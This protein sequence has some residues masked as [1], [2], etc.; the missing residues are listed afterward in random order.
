MSNLLRAVHPIA[1]DFL[2]TMVFAA[3]FGLTH[4]L[5]LAL[6]AALSVGV[7]QIAWRR[8]RGEPIEL[9][10][11]AGLGLAL[12]FGG[13]SLLAHDVRFV[14]FKPTL[15]YVAV[16]AV[17]LKPGWMDRY[18]PPIVH[19][20]LG[21]AALTRWG[22]A[23]AA[24]M[25]ATAAA[26]LALALHSD[27]KLWGAFITIGP[28]ASKLVLFAAQYLSLRLQVRRRLARSLP[29]AEPVAA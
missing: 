29:A 2:S 23:W 24:L 4:N 6:G 22:Y 14:L 19:E 26:N 1:L 17:M 5:A 20:R 16:G 7:G 8:L 11:W 21:A 10:Q 13:A 28:L 9:M 27:L 18:A 3:A 15:I 25:F 12:V